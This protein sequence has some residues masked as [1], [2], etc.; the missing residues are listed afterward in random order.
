[1]SENRL[2]LTHGADWGHDK[3]RGPQLEVCLGAMRDWDIL[4]VAPTGI[5]KS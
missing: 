1:M 4:L 2:R 5:G 3:F